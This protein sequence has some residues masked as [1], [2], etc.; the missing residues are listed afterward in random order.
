MKR[1]TQV[2]S[3]TWL[4]VAA[5]SGASVQS[6]FQTVASELNGARGNFQAETT[7]APAT[8]AAPEG[9]RV[10]PEVL[11]FQATD[12]KIIYD[13]Y[14][15]LQ[16]AVTRDA[17]DAI[18]ALMEASGGFIAAASVS[19]VSGDEQ[20]QIELTVRLPATSSASP[21]TVSAPWPTRWFRSP[22]VARMSPP[23]LSTSK[24]N[25]RT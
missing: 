6:E 10:L 20:P 5:C 17:F 1:M 16:A 3:V 24:P 25:S 14:M 4:V 15:Q 21:L 22:S 11:G 18:T 19:E 13:G 23:S 8:T 2:M 7:A 9:A 12:R